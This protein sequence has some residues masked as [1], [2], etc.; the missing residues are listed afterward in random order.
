MIFLFLGSFLAHLEPKLQLFEVD[1]H[2]DAGNDDLSHHHLLKFK[3][4]GQGH[5]D[6]LTLWDSLAQ[7]ESQ[8]SE[9]LLKIFNQSKRHVLTVEALSIFWVFSEILKQSLSPIGLRREWGRWWGSRRKRQWPGTTWTQSE[10]AALLDES[11]QETL[12]TSYSQ[13][14]DEGVGQPLN[15]LLE[16]ESTRQWEVEGFRVVISR[17]SAI[18]W[19]APSKVEVGQRA[20]HQGQG[21]GLW[22]KCCFS[23]ISFTL[24]PPSKGSQPI[25]THFQRSSQHNRPRTPRPPLNGNFQTFFY[26]TFFFCNWILLMGRFPQIST[27]QKKWWKI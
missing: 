14:S 10:A 21:R 4:L 27:E 25:H 3:H 18:F 26:P 8:L 24:S 1:D 7:R 19:D 23:N 11:S 17:V 15:V 2:G 20:K 5:L 16:N 12:E 6:V 22:R 9:L 13:E